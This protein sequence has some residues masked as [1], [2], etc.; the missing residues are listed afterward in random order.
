VLGVLAGIL[1]FF[2][3]AKPTVAVA[4]IK[5]NEEQT[6]VDESGQYE[7]RDGAI[8]PLPAAYAS[9]GNGHPVGNSSSQGFTIEGRYSGRDYSG[10]T[11]TKEQVID[12]IKEYSLRY[13]IDSSLPLRVANCESGYNWSSKNRSSS[14]SGVFQYIASTWRNTEAGRAGLSPFDAD[15]NVHMAI[16]SIASGG[17]GNWNASRGC[18]SNH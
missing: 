5:S 16:A 15:A 11:W 9:G 14:A 1:L 12:L 4:P 8:K 6:I 2:L 7:I 3:L 18:W 10:Q 13:N 17:I